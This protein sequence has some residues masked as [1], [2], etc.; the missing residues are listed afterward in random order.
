MH[1]LTDFFSGH[2]TAFFVFGCPYRFLHNTPGLISSGAPCNAA[3][4]DGIF[5][6]NRDTG[7]AVNGSVRIFNPDSA[8]EVRDERG[9]SKKSETYTRNS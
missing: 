8:L 4:Q 7:W 5:F 6:L 1:W 3:K 2:E 9:K